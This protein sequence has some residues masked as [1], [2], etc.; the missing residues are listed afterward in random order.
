MVAAAKKR[1]VKKATKRRGPVASRPTKP[2]KWE[3]N[4]KKA[5]QSKKF[6]KEQPTIAGMEDVDERIP[7]LDDAC[8]RH[9][10]AKDK[11]TIGKSEER[12]A[13]TEIT[14]G[15]KEHGLNLY[16]HQGRKF[17]IEPGSESLKVVQ[18]KQ[19]G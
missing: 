12:E 10:A 1:T 13:A 16:L 17:Y 3:G 6:A 2:A 15:I 7:E 4:G 11:Q 9:E 18:V 19:K 14:A 8:Q 5:G